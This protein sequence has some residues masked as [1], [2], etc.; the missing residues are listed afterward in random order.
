VLRYDRTT[1]ATSIVLLVDAV[2]D[3]D[4]PRAERADADAVL[5]KPCPAET[6]FTAIQELLGQSDDLRKRARKAR[7]AAEA[8]IDIA[9]RVLARSEET[10][11]RM[12]TRRRTVRERT[13]EPPAPPLT[14]TCP[15]CYQPLRYEYSQLGGVGKH[16]EQWDHYR[17][18]GGC[19]TYNYRQRTGK[20]TRLT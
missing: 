2:D 6:L 4:L 1:Q 8:Q 20:I 7:L 17:C 15:A 11:A 5:V 10:Y 14:L 19:G 18:P 3:P 13:T 12:A 9:G 16:P